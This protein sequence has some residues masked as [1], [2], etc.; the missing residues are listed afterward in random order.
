M[1]ENHHLAPVPSPG[2]DPDK[3]RRNR[4]RLMIA[5]A[6][7]YV[8]LILAGAAFATTRMHDWARQRIVDSVTV[9]LSEIETAARRT[10]STAVRC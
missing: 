9:L 10:L 4:R 3:R 6:L 8:V 5:G 2:H 7:V 1:T